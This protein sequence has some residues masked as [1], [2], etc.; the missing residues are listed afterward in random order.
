MEIAKN[1]V[2]DDPI[3][4]GGE[5]CVVENFVVSN[6]ITCIVILACFMEIFM[7]LLMWSFLLLVWIH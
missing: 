6:E 3:A 2:M 7:L 1:L 4:I 5:L